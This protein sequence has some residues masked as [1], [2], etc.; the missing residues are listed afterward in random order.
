MGQFIEVE[1]HFTAGRADAVMITKA[2]VFIFEFKIAETSTVEKAL[3]QIDD[4]GYTIPYSASD[5]TIVKVGVVF[6][7]EKRGITDWKIEE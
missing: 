7:K 4:K 2:T 5:Q 3:Q 6:S 1:P